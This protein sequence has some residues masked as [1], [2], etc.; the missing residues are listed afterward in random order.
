MNSSEQ[1]AEPGLGLAENRVALR[2]RVGSFGFSL[3]GLFQILTGC[4]LF[5]ALLRVSP[6]FAFCAT[7]MTTPGIVRTAIASDCY[8]SRGIRF[9]WVTRLWTF[10]ESFL[11]TLLTATVMLMVFVL[12]TFLFGLIG[13]AA[14]IVLGIGDK[15]IDVSFIS[16][17]GGMVWGFGGAMIA[18][19]Y[20]ARF[21]RIKIGPDRA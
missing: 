21:W 9:C 5:F 8:F 6:L 7:I 1:S 12:I 3:M 11:I 19:T 20:C 17:C 13:I 18:A 2:R 16:A 10:V 15:L 14:A 4:C